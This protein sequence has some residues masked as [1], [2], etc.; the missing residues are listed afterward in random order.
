[1]AKVM[2][3]DVIEALDRMTTNQREEFDYIIDLKEDGTDAAVA[4][5]TALQILDN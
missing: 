3:E 2:D 1:M 5:E 4:L